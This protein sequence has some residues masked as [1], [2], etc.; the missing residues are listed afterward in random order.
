MFCVSTFIK[1]VHNLAP[2]YR[3]DLIIAIRSSSLSS[4]TRRLRSSSIAHIQLSPGPRTMARY[5]DRAFPVKVP[6]LWNKLPTDVRAAP[7]LDTFE[8]Q[9]KIHLF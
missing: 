4:A 6:T 9:L 3:Q 1:A 2:V 7:S 5:G 8:S